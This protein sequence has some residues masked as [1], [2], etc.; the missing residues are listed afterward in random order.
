MYSYIVAASFTNGGFT[1]I[2]QMDEKPAIEETAI[3]D[4][5]SQQADVDIRL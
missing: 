4:G 1:D 2:G 3:V 5:S